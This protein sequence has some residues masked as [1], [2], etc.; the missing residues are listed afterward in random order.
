MN[1]VTKTLLEELGDHSI[2]EFVQWWDAFEGTVIRVYKT[3]TVLEE[4]SLRLLEAREA[5]AHIIG[6]W[7][8]VLKPYW[9]DLLIDGAPV[10]AD[11]YR[12]LLDFDRPD[13]FID[14]WAAMQTLP[15]AREAINR[16]LWE[17]IRKKG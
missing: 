12:H 5:I 10:S 16:F 8:V 15:V 9:Q 11:P 4:D 3:K 17:E 1:P 6:R 14:N 7:Q 13:S 2:A